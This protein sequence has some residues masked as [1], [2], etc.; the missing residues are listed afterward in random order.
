MQS[1]TTTAGELGAVDNYTAMLWIARTMLSQDVCPSVCPS[2]CLSVTP[3]QF[4]FFC[5]KHYGNIP[6]GGGAS[7][8]GGME[9]RHLRP[10]SRF[11]AK[12]IQDRTTVT[13]E[14]EHE[15]V[16]R[17]SNGT[18]LNDCE[19]PL[20]HISRSRYYSTSN[21]SKSRHYLTHNVSETIQDTDRITMKYYGL[22]DALYSTVSFRM[23][24]SDL[25][26]HRNIHRH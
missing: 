12:M 5:I 17:L 21:N 20:T 25:E 1:S 18:I 22:T 24:L 19:W 16:P 9:N 4:S 15:A 8:T 13:M 3:H 2:A 23:T 14:C 10:I 26:R 11:I 7:N 6:N